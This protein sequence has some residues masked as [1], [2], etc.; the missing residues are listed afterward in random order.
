MK[1]GNLEQNTIKFTK[2]FWHFGTRPK[3]AIQ[4]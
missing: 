2:G 4:L 1:F 3:K